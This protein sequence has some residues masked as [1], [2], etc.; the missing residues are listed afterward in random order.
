[1]T[2]ADLEAAVAVRRPLPKETPPLVVAMWREATGDWDGAHELAQS[3]ESTDGAWVHAYLHRKEGDSSNARYWY[4]RA[5]R[6]PA[7][8]SL[9]EEWRTIVSALLER[10]D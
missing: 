2:L 5:D 10:I 8:G 9:D 7:S 3:V 6:P 1:M 4:R